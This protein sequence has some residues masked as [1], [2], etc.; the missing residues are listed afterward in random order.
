MPK[1]DPNKRA[2]TTISDLTKKDFPTT[3]PAIAAD[4]AITAAEIDVISRAT[5][6]WP[7]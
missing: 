1:P 6:I 7:A 2:I 3:G 5:Y 4:G